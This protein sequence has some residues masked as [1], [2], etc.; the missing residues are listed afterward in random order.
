REVVKLYGF[1]IAAD[2]RVDYGRVAPDAA[3]EIFIAE[4]LVAR[5]LAPAGDGASA[6]GAGDAT[7]ADEDVDAAHARDAKHGAQRGA[8]SAQPPP[9]AARNRALRLEVQDWETC[10]RRRD[11]YAGD[12]QAVRFYDERLPRGVR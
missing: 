11:L 5:G 3:R 1:T 4:A 8:P 2:K 6:A 7:L 10:L 12:A 9:F